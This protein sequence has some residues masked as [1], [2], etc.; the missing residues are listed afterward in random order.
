MYKSLVLF[1]LKEGTDPD[2][3]FKY[4]IQVHAEDVKKVAGPELLKKLKR[5]TVSRVVKNQGDLKIFGI[6]EMWWESKEDSEEYMRASQ[7]YKTPS[8]KTPGEDFVS[9]IKPLAIIELDQVV[10]KA[11]T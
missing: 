7:Q 1:D 6:V 4:H 11:T 2:E 5:Y 9:R 10:I 8:G 3:F